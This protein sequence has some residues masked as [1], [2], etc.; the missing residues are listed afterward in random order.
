MLHFCD[1]FGIFMTCF[2]LTTPAAK[3]NKK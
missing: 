1:F 3:K 2:V